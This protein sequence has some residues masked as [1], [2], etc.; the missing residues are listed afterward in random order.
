MSTPDDDPDEAATNTFDPLVPRPIDLPTVLPAG[1]VLDPAVGDIAKVFA[2][3]DDPADWPRWRED[4]SAWRDDACRRL[5]YEGSGYET[6]EAERAAR[7]LSVALVWLWDERLFD[8]DAGGFTVDRFL[9]ATA[10]AG[11]FDGIVLWHAYPIIGIDD[12]NQFDFYRE[13]P[14]IAELVA[15]F[16][17]HGL[18]VFLDYNPWDTGTRRTGNDDAAEL[19]LLTAELGTDGVFLDTLKQA[20]DRLISAL[21]SGRRPQLLE[22]SPACRTRG[23]AT[24]SS[25]GRSGS[26]T[27]PHP[28]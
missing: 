10:D 4:L 6:P 17:A 19:A 16:Q 26:P 11:G 14:G 1:G 25:A 12:R 28:E 13:V 15:E 22:G 24:T 20:D 18:L 8:R 9:S 3:P 5:G 7:C 2:A 27:A 21:R 23:S